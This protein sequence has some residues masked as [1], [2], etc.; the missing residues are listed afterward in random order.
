MVLPYGSHIERERERRMVQSSDDVLGRQPVVRRSRVVLEVTREILS[1]FHVQFFFFFF[2]MWLQSLCNSLASGCCY[3]SSNRTAM[4]L[5]SHAQLKSLWTAC[6]T[7][8]KWR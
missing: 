2:F 5:E 6:V 8:A 3:I 4:S 7:E 1:D